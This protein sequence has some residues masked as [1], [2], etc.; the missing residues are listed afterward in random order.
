MKIIDN[1]LDIADFYT[2]KNILTG[3]NFPWFY[4]DDKV[5]ATENIKQ[6][7]YNYQ[8]VHVFFR[9]NAINSA[10]FEKLEVFQKILN[11]HTIIRIKANLTT[12]QKK[13]IP[14]DYHTDIPLLNKQNYK[15]AIYYLNTTNGP[16]LFENGE[17]VDCVENRLVIFDGNIPHTGCT[18]TNSK[19]RVVI[20]FNY[21]ES[22]EPQ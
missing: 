9:E 16:S 3:P 2:V 14:Y 20:N 8:F 11:S 7:L 10:Y 18:H 21:F 19:Y 5:G 22:D 4:S 15:T 13:V 1:V 6:K 17:K 12:A